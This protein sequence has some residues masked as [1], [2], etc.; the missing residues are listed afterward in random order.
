VLSSTGI[1]DPVLNTIKGFPNLETL[2]L[3]STGL[4]DRGLDALKDLKALGLLTL[5]NTN[6]SDTAIANLKKALPNLI[7]DTGR[8]V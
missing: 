7:V 4:T 8:E 5:H 6:V 2:K 3:C 1:T